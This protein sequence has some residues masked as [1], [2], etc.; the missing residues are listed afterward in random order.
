MSE[1]RT[2]RSSALRHRLRS[3][4]RRDETLPKLSRPLVKQT[5]IRRTNSS[6]K[7]P[8]TSST[9]T[10]MRRH[11]RSTSRSRCVTKR[12]RKAGN[13]RLVDQLLVQSHEQTDQP[14]LTRRG[15]AQLIQQRQQAKRQRNEQQ[16]DRRRMSRRGHGTALHELAQCI[17]HQRH[18]IVFV[19]GAG[20]SIASGIRPFRST[21]NNNNNLTNCRTLTRNT[22]TMSS[23][24]SL[25]LS[26]NHSVTRDCDSQ[27]QQ[28]QQ[29]P[30]QHVPSSSCSSSG[31]WDSVLWTTAT[32]QAFR[33]NPLDWYNTFWIPYFVHCAQTRT[34]TDTKSRLSM[35][36]DR[37]LTTSSGTDTDTTVSLTTNTSTTSDQS[38]TES[39]TNSTSNH[40]HHHHH[41]TND[42]DTTV[43]HPNAGHVALD[44]L[45]DNYPKTIQQITQNIDGL[46]Q[47]SHDRTNLIQIHGN[48]SWFRCVPNDD[49]DSE[50][51]DANSVDEEEEED[52]SLRSDQAGRMV[53]LG[54]RTKSQQRNVQYESPLTC[55]Y[56]YLQSL[57]VS[58]LVFDKELDKTSA[59]SGRSSS[60]VWQSLP[61][62]LTSV[63]RCPVCHNIVMPQALLFDEGYHSHSF[64]EFE[65]A[66]DWIANA[67]VIVFVG[68][69][70]ANIRLTTLTLQHAR[71]RGIAVYNINP[72]DTLQATQWLNVTNIQDDATKVLPR[73]VR[74]V[75][76]LKAQI[77][78]KPESTTNNQVRHLES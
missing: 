68:T 64:Y 34:R 39:V 19:T 10:T 59:A 70:F 25:S 1:R 72:Y 56:Q 50:E 60:F 73:L 12:P 11:S 48:A 3:K 6:Q 17:V 52:G 55:P 71:K 41:S 30:S 63:P 47:P 8:R 75:E 35:Y 7:R 61:N 21:S 67:D 5:P 78:N 40:H 76:E 46:Q 26:S 69:S 4:N 16:K 45:L 53:H 22:T 36:Q 24:S 49:S 37:A 13:S 42:T 43:Y 65:R 33:N 20:L 9:T 27:Q 23:S 54:S 31:L 28:Q 44:T 14:R 58:Q 18:S 66:E 29:Q 62:R 51:D 57:P 15:I 32:R 38:E 77:K 74:L 2:T